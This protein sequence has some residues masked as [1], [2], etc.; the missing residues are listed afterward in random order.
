MEASDRSSLE[1]PQ[2]PI[3]R[4]R[5]VVTRVVVAL[6]LDATVDVQENDEET[7]ARVDGPEEFGRL[8]GRQGQ[9]IDALQPL[10]WGA[11]FHDAD[12]RK[13]V[14]VDAAGYRARRE[15]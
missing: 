11:A 2:K 1:V 5:E 12:E 6:G 7:R 14:V 15:E 4:V 10:A 9:T 8:I 13:A 3:E